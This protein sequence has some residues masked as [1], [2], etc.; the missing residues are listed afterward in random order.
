MVMTLPIDGPERLG[1][2][3]TMAP[4]AVETIAA[5]VA[6]VREGGKNGSWLCYQGK[7]NGTDRAPGWHSLLFVMHVHVCYNNR[8]NSVWFSLSRSNLLIMIDMI[9]SV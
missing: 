3:G 1:E 9:L 7:Q 6:M 2:D 4:L 8:T 5:D